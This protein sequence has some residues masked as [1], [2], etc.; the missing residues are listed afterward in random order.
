MCFFMLTIIRNTHLCNTSCY[1]WWCAEGTASCTLES[2]ERCSRLLHIR[3]P[4]CDRSAYHHGNT[5]TETLIQSCH[6]L[7]E[8]QSMDISNSTLYRQ[9]T[10]PMILP[11]PVS[12]MEGWPREGGSCILYFAETAWNY[13]TKWN[14]RSITPQPTCPLVAKTRHARVQR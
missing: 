11:L 13:F 14:Y 7:A 12:F 10:K 1:E 3:T 2:D 8:L 4:T 5:H 6:T 9:N